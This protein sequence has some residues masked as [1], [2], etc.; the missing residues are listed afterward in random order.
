MART[1]RLEF[2]KALYH[3]ISRG[4]EKKAI[5]KDKKDYIKLLKILKETKEKF[6]YKL[7]V[8]V[9]MPNHYHFIIETLN[10]NLSRIMHT[11]N[12]GYTTWFNHRYKRSGHLFQ[13]RYKS[14]LVDKDTYLLEL[15]RYIHLNPLRANIVSSPEN[16][17][18]SSYQE[19]TK[20]SK[21]RLVDKKDIMEYFNNNS[22]RFEEFVKDGINTP[23]KIDR[24]YGGFILG[25]TKFIKETLEK[26]KNK[27]LKEE[28]S[29][30]K[31]LK[32]NI[33]KEDILKEVV[34][35]YKLKETH[36]KKS[37]SY[38]NRVRKVSI[39]LLKKYTPM[40]N[41]E[42]GAEFKISYSGI[43]KVKNR[44]EH[45]IKKNEQLKKEIEYILSR[46]KG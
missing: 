41:K 31:E 11:I 45:E 18:Y 21:Y 10:A 22:K 4:N 17:E 12:S 14:I 27:E 43:S 28:I 7:Y 8:Y 46:V 30:R 36:I 9:L 32:Q 39:Y 15:S 34:S 24:P 40:Q 42:I 1:L 19:Y 13:G 16:Y 44:L 25:S 35:Y 5:F 3:I 29:Y 38:L 6:N 23:I 2:K 26:I 33:S 37:K 20:K